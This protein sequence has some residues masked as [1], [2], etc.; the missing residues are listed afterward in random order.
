[1]NAVLLPQGLRDKHIWL[2]I[3]SLNPYNNYTRLQRVQVAVTFVFI[4]MIVN[5]MFYGVEPPGSMSTDIG[6]FSFGYGEVGS[7]HG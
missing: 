4:A 2:G 1:M 7:G 3:F 5:M 6:E